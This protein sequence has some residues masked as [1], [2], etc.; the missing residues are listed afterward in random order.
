[1]SST[2][3]TPTVLTVTSGAGAASGEKNYITNPSMATATTGWNVVGDFA[4]TRSTSASELPREYTTAT[5]IKMVATAGTQSTADYIFFDFILDDVDLNKKM[6]IKWSQKRLGTYAAGQLAVIITTQSDRTTALHTPITTAIP[7]VDTEFETTFDSGSTAALSIVIRATADMTT[8]DG[9]CLS[10]VIVGPGINAQGAAIS[11]WQSYTPT[12]SNLGGGSV[13]S[14]GGRWRRVG[15]NMEILV[16]FTTTGVG[17]GASNVTC[18]IPS[19]YTI[20]SNALPTS[21]TSG[22]NKL[23]SYSRYNGSQWLNDANVAAASSTTLYFIE[24][25]TAAVLTGADFPSGTEFGFDALFPIAEWAGNGTVNLG[26]GAQ[27]EYASTVSTGWDSDQISAADTRYGP[28]GSQVTGSLAATRQKRVFFQYPIQA[29]DLIALEFSNDGIVWTTGYSV[30][31]SVPVLQY[32]NFTALGSPGQAGA[33]VQR[34]GTNSV[35]VFFGRYQSARIDDGTNVANWTSGF[36]RV[37]KAKASSPVGF[38]RASPATGF[39]LVAPR[40]GQT[41]LTVTSSAS[42]WSTTRAVGIYYQD[43]DGN[44]RLKLNV[45]GI[46]TGKTYTSDTITVSGV[47]FKNVSNFFQSCSGN[48]F[49]TSPGSVTQCYASPNTSTITLATSSSGGLQTGLCISGDV[50]LESAPTWA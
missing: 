37:R 25:G 10:D 35:D 13:N 29:D 20:D 23:G 49:G 21:L 47:T 50:E 39:G 12:I 45:M 24:P 11:E 6:K 41:T 43:Q 33:A 5:G 44:H 28:G 15:S 30:M 2:A 38:S 8:N 31:N 4:L 40:R 32:S 18:S 19:G 1:M 48:T 27:V 17:S 3:F 9:L 26:P 14:S 7:A 22:R 16:T 34:S 36:W 46:F 42:G